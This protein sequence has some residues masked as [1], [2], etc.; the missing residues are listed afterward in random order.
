MIFSK[1]RVLLCFVSH[2]VITIGYRGSLELR[3]DVA[4]ISW[5]KPLVAD[6]AV[7]AL[8]W[9]P[10]PSIRYPLHNYHTSHTSEEPQRH[11]ASH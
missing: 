2:L 5:H 4:M 8:R 6:S 1:M 11:Q 7:M 10:F 9:Y 3:G